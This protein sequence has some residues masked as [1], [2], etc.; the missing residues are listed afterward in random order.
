MIEPAGCPKC[1]QGLSSAPGVP[2]NGADEEW[3]VS[4]REGNGHAA[5]AAENV[6]TDLDEMIL[7]IEVVEGR[8]LAYIEARQDQPV[9][10]VGSL[11]PPIC[12]SGSSDR[13]CHGGQ[14]HARP[15]DGSG[16]IGRE[17]RQRW[18]RNMFLRV[19]VR[20]WWRDARPSRAVVLSGITS[21][22]SFGQ[23]CSTRVAILHEPVIP[24]GASTIRGMEEFIVSGCRLSRRGTRPSG[25]VRNR[26]RRLCGS[27]GIVR[28]AVEGRRRW[29]D[30]SVRRPLGISDIRVPRADRT[31]SRSRRSSRPGL[32]QLV[33]TRQNL[34]IRVENGKGTIVGR[35]PARIRGP[36]FRA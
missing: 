31:P 34:N 14:C 9:D 33:V 5:D 3:I 27:P 22:K 26:S 24:C 23:P 30:C 20:T 2:W 28:L 17:P 8:L 13:P 25:F 1:R 6:T 19:F 15:V 35:L 11:R 18:K 29:S 7:R 36:K 21:P 16:E 4:A 32:V 10:L 12:L